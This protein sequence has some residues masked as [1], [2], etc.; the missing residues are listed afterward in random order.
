M[1][2]LWREIRSGREW[3]VVENPVD[4]FGSVDHG[5]LLALLERRRAERE[6]LHLIRKIFDDDIDGEQLPIPAGRSIP[7]AG[8]ALPTMTGTLARFHSEM[9]RRGYDL[10]RH[11]S[12]WLINC[13]SPAEARSA[14][15]D[16]R[17]IMDQ[18]GVVLE[19]QSSRVVQIRDRFSFPGDRIRRSRSR[20]PKRTVFSGRIARDGAGARSFSFGER[21]HAPDTRPF[22]ASGPN[23]PRPAG[24]GRWRGFFRL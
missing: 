15:V 22:G 14:M 19:A 2:R 17:Q 6:T 13:K 21:E 18:L 16:A 20:T 12:D 23:S 5:K 7:E 11:G 24:M 10:T 4:L 8:P 1:P 9:R 3:T